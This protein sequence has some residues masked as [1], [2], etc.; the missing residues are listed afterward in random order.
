MGNAACLHC[1]TIEKNGFVWI[2]IQR[3]YSK[4]ELII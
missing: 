1:N 4:L 3:I 2:N